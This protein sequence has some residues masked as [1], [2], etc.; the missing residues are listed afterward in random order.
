MIL[1]AD[2]A[3]RLLSIAEQR[4]EHLSTFI[5]ALNGLA[6]T[7]VV[8]IWTFFL[9][10]F[11]DT[12]AFLNPAA[13]PEDFQA[14]AYSYVV[15]AAGLSALVL[16]L[17]RLY[18]RYIDDEIAN[19]YPE[20]M[21]YEQVLGVGSYGG[22]QKYI[23]KQPQ[24]SIAFAQLYP[25]QRQQL[26][27]HLVEDRR[28]GRRGH[29]VIYAIVFVALF[30][31]IAAILGDVFVQLDNQTLNKMVSINEIQNN[32]LLVLKWIGYILMAVGSLVC[33]YAF[34]HFQRNPTREYVN[35]IVGKVRE[36]TTS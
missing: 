32:P 36:E 21:S 23:L 2:N 18:A 1:Y 13:K 5:T 15:A 14:F 16:G 8:G 27:K 33:V 35:R 19:I 29:G 22:I 11:S 20:I 12:S 28:I 4:R 31:F 30:I 9:K 34:F 3:G 6:I 10:S 24:I 17:W 7:I 26:V 25:K